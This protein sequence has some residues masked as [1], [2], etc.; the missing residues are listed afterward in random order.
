[1]H[2]SGYMGEA[3][4]SVWKEWEGFN[5]RGEVPPPPFRAPSLCTATVPLTASASFNGICNR[6]QPPPTALGTSSDPLFDRCW[7][8]LRGP[9]PSNAS[10][11]GAHR[12]WSSVLDVPSLWRRTG[13]PGHISAH[14]S[15]CHR[16]GQCLALL[17]RCCGV[18]TPTSIMVVPCACGDART[19]VHK[20]LHVC[21]RGL[22]CV[23][24]SSSSS[25]MSGCP[26]RISCSSLPLPP[27]LPSAGLWRCGQIV[28][29]IFA[30]ST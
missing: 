10:L 15:H 17:S 3:C 28:E 6:Q 20:C 24:G 9:F 14:A 16:H 25:V 11:A 4:I 21:C 13:H 2:A 12:P 8:R 5:G 7:G 26:C 29:G 27:L 18:H 19:G 23:G 22:L 1:M 30:P